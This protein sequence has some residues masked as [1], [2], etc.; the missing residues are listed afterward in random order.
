MVHFV[1]F[2]W[3]AINLFA[4]IGSVFILGCA[5]NKYHIAIQDASVLNV[6]IRK[7]FK[8]I[9]RMFFSKCFHNVCFMSLSMLIPTNILSMFVECLCTYK[10]CPH[11]NVHSMFV[12]WSFYVCKHLHT[13]IIQTAK[14]CLLSEGVLTILALFLVIF[15]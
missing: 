13:N 4:N 3:G 5:M 11:F 8:N 12:L 10:T 6:N 14:K 7:P 1:Q 2:C 9:C 15:Q